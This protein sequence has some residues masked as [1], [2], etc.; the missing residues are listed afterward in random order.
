MIV[1]STVID[2][3]QLGDLLRDQKANESPVKAFRT[4]NAGKIRGAQG[5]C[6]TKVFY[7]SNQR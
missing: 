2:Q 7:Q 5:P 6:T 1:A 3:A 4:K